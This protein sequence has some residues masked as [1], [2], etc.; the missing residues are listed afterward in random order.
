MINDTQL[1]LFDEPGKR[2][3]DR[4]KG[5]MVRLGANKACIVCGLDIPGTLTAAHIHPEDVALTIYGLD[6]VFCL[7]WTHHYGFYDQGY[8]T[9]S[10]LLCAED[11]WISETNRPVPHA[12]DLMVTKKL[13]S[14]QLVRKNRHVLNRWRKH[15]EQMK[16]EAASQQDESTLPDCESL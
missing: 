13:Q 6:R 16:A 11:V 10:D 2:P 8:I 3:C 5:Y 12:R 4:R 1:F 7:C 14:G 9:T 15:D